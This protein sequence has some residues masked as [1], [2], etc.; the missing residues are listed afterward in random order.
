MFQSGNSAHP[1]ASRRQPKIPIS[2]IHLRP[3]FPLASSRVITVLRQ[4][5]GSHSN[6]SAA[7]LAAH[8]QVGENERASCCCV[9]WGVGDGRSIR[10]LF[11]WQLAEMLRGDVEFN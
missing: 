9:S 8:R 6:P 5:H 11:S 7:K 10:Q 1:A 2:C 4:W 3:C